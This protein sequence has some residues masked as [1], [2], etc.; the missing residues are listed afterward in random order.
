MGPSV[1]LAWLCLVDDALLSIVYLAVF[2]RPCIDVHLLII[3]DLAVSALYSRI[4]WNGLE[5]NGY[6][7]IKGN[8]SS[9]FDH[10]HRSRN[11]L[12]H[13]LNAPTQVQVQVLYGSTTRQDSQPPIARCVRFICR[14]APP[15]CSA[16]CSRLWMH[17]EAAIAG[18]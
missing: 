11:T 7:S 12:K 1:N 4:E 3:V 5:W 8:R 10:T 15:S 14:S 16:L 2:G 9:F 13:H 6:C 17:R 18:D